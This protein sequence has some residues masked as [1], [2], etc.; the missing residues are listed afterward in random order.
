MTTKWT[1]IAGLLL[2]MVSA[3]TA[4]EKLHEE[5]ITYNNGQ[6]DVKAMLV[7][8]A[9]E[10]PHPALITIHEWYG[11][12]EWAKNQA[13]MF[14]HGG[15][16]VLAVDLY[17]GEVAETHDHAH[18]L[19]RGL[20]DDRALRD[21]NGAIDYL[22][23]HEAAGDKLGV[24]GWCMGGGYAL[25]LAMTGRT[26]ASVVCYGRLNADPDALAEINGPL[27]GIFGGEDRGIAPKTVR[28][29]DEALGEAEVANEV[30]IYDGVGHAFLR[31][32]YGKD[33]YKDYIVRRAWGEI[34]EF[35]EMV[36][37][38]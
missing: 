6:E 30:H 31:H 15:Y 8:P 19:S 9:T 14:A 24:I 10:G 29:F 13:R 26:D 11:L 1:L 16:T 5:T 17:R 7:R 32:E 18:E 37:K 38:D 22:Q 25:K 28:Q 36:L 20:P 4:Q 3:L 2:G 34:D 33:L 21:L 23:A 27:L 12:N 35:F